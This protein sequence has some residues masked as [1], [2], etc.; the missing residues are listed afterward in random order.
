MSSATAGASRMLG[1][2]PAMRVRLGAMRAGDRIRLLEV[3]RATGVFREEEVT[4]AAELFDATFGASATAADAPDGYRFVGAF[5]EHDRLIGYACYG[6]TPGTVGTW[7]LYWIAV[8]PALHGAGVGSA[9]MGEVERRLSAERAHLVVVE[10]SSRSDYAPTRRFYERLG[11]V[12]CARVRDFY[13]RG[14]DRIILVKRFH[15]P[16]QG[17]ERGHHE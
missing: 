4:V 3:V 16:E 8:D 14:D 1:E 5:G 17:G 13:A 2:A 12:E 10:T 11:Y 7:D 9:I 15:E 6:L